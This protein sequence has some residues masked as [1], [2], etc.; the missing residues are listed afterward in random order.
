VH[1]EFW[2][3]LYVALDEDGKISFITHF[4]EDGASP[5]ENKPCGWRWRWKRMRRRRRRRRR[6]MAVHTKSV[7]MFITYTRT[8]LLQWFGRSKY[9]YIIFS[10]Y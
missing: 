9:F 4:P 6:R 8:C 10:K 2:L 5:K 3:F 1:K 7:G